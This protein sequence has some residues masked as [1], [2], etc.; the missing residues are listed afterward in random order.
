MK[1]VTFKHSSGDAR[2]GIRTPTFVID[3]HEGIR[4][5]QAQA[6]ASTLPL[7]WNHAGWQAPDSMMEVVERS[8]ET[9]PVLRELLSL[10]HSGQTP[11]VTHA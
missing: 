10:S 1:L 8:G 7:P 9:L 11:G 6:G 5:L 4:W 3:V 2:V